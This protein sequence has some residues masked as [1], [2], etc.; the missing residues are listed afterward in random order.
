VKKNPLL[1]LVIGVALLL[2]GGFMSFGRGP[3]KADSAIVAQC[4]ER[5]RDQGPEMTSRCEEK[6]F[7]TGMTATDANEA[8]RTISAANNDEVGGNMIGMF[9]LGVG[10]VLA[11]AGAYI[12]RQQSAARAG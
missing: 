4:K 10:I 1:L 7:A 5:L 9:L 6:A 2:A 12:M 11:G 8:A 3:A